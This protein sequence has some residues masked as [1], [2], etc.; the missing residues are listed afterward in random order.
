MAPDARRGGGIRRTTAHATHNTAVLP[1]EVDPGDGTVT[2]ETRVL[3]V[4]PVSEVP[5][6]RRYLP[7][8]T[9][10]RVTGSLSLFR[11]TRRPTWTRT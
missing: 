6:S 9:G 7:G 3:A 8:L 2:L 10:R 11:S 1:I 4:E 5:L